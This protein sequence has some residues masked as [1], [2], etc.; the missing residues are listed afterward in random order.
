MNARGLFFIFLLVA[1]GGA[2]AAFTFVSS[3]V[4]IAIGGT[5]DQFSYPVWQWW[6]T[7]ADGD[8]DITLWIILSGLAGGLLSTVALIAFISAFRY[9]LTW[10]RP[11]L[12]AQD[13]IP[14]PPDPA[15]SDNFGHASWANLDDVLA[16]WSSTD[17]SYGAIVLGEAYDPRID[18]GPFRPLN[19]STWGHGGKA[20]LLLD[21]CHTGSTHSLIIAGSGSFKTVSAVSS[22]LTWTGSAVVLDPAEELGPM[23]ERDRQRLGH[24]VFVLS[25]QSA[26]TTGFNVLDWIDINSPMAE[27]NVD[28]VVEWICGHTERRDQKEDAQFFKDRGKDLVRCMLTQILWDPDLPQSAKTLRTLRRFLSRPEDELREGLKAIAISSP[29]LLARQ[30]A[31]TLSGLVKETFSGV[32]GNA[33]GDS[34]WLSTTAYADLVSGNSFKTSDIANGKTDVF[35]SL[36]LKALE[37][38]P[39]VARCIIGALLNSAYEANGAVNGRIL[40]LLDEAARLGPM[41]A[42]KVAFNAGRKYG[43]T[44]QFL[45]QSIGQIQQQWGREGKHD[46]YEGAAFRSYAALSDYE[47]AEELAKTIGQRG[48]RMIS[49]SANTGLSVPQFSIFGSRQRGKS[50]NYSEMGRFLIRPEELLHDLRTDA[51]IVVPQAAKPILCGRA[52]YFRRPEFV[53]RVDANRFTKGA[54]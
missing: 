50:Y 44:L 42:I 33:T 31:S 26:G 12:R 17:P 51:Q 19:R 30:L 46:L 40:F 39:A 49:E 38:T 18:K 10:S 32:Y 20:P 23:L 22:L 8:P 11:R 6:L 43:I 2:L 41:S 27:P 47:T 14:D 5:E 4:L 34:R 21:A 53:R 25:P 36:P 35:L 7:L 9:T 28:A 29:S 16:E 3:E 45:Y 15:V 48:V 54:A 52:L 1:A 24:K 37:A 13:H